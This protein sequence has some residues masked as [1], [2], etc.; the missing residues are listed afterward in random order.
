VVV[1]DANGNFRS[2]FYGLSAE[3]HRL[4]FGEECDCA[5]HVECDE[6]EGCKG[7]ESEIEFAPDPSIDG[8]WF[9]PEF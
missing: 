3:R 7:L 9:E 6:R 8:A 4:I 2:A 1:P 5:H